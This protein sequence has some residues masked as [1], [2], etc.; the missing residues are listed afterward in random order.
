MKA[1]RIEPADNVAVVAQDTRKGDVLRH[2]G[3]EVTALEDIGL[4]HK[5]AVEAVA[6]GG[7]VRKYGVPIGRASAPIAAGAFVHTHNLGAVPAV[8]R[9]VQGREG[10]MSSLQAFPRADGSVGIRNI[11]L[12]VSTVTCANTVVNHIAWKTGAVPLTH[13]RGCVE[14][15][16]S[17]RRTLTT[18]A[19]HPNVS[20]VLIVGLGCEQ[21]RTLDLQVAIGG[22]KPVHAIL[23]QEEG[24]SV[25]AEARGCELVREMQR[26]A[27]DLERQPCPLSGLVVG[28]QCGGSDW[29]TAI[30]GNTVIGAMTDLVIAA[31]GS[32]LMSEVPG[33]PGCEH[34][35]ASR[36]VSREAGEQI[37]GMVDELRAEFLRAHGQPIEA[38]NPTPGNK[39]GGITTL[40]EK[41]M[42]NIKKMGTSPVQGVLKLGERPPHPGL[43]IVDNRAN[44]P[45]PVNLAGFAMA[46][47]SA[48]VFS[49]GR[50]SPVGSPVMPV[51]KL[52]GNPHTYA[53]MPGLMDFNAGVVVDGADIGETGRALYDLLLEVAGGR[54]TRS[55]EN[56]DYEFSIPYEEAR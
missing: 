18:F 41:A 20:G 8:R 49:T 11:V 9:R 23:I 17:F 33:I 37:L 26:A 56:G 46:G 45:D 35:V 21:I 16:Q 25:E 47:A 40:V 24:G 54:P 14:G 31:G 29:T 44:G 22:G 39:A 4:G 55:E 53:K 34:I 5:I 19:K 1:L 51:V 10:R 3:G 36:A 12:V 32:V 6:Q 38:V 30:A 48:T 2:A 50:G 13:E 43:W 28:V 42:G 27:Q 15:E 7:L 52:T